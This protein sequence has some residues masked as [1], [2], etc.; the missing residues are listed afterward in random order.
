[1]AKPTVPR[2]CQHCQV[3]F[4]CTNRQVKLGWGKFCSQRCSGYHRPRPSPIDSFN[5]HVVKTE[6]GCWIWQ[7]SRSR[8]Y[9]KMRYGREQYAHRIAYILFVGAIGSLDVLHRCDTPSC[10]NPSHLFLGTHTDNMQDASRKGRMHHKLTTEQVQSILTDRRPQTVIA[11]EYNVTPSHVC[12]LKA[13]QRR[14][15]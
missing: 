5:K 10:V 15:R 3:S 8:G 1:M 14:L 7:G 11:R 9:G 6:N 12:K 13:G 2:T 4:K